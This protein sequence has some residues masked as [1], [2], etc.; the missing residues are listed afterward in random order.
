M[1]PAAVAQPSSRSVA[2]RYLSYYTSGFVDDTFF[3]IIGPTAG[4]ALQCCTRAN[5]SAAWYSL[6]AVLY[7]GQL[8]Q[9]SCLRRLKLP[10]TG[11]W[12]WVP[13]DRGAHYLA[14]CPCSLNRAAAGQQ[15]L[16][17]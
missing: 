14:P 1:L 13:D 9:H 15:I 16:T 5:D 8:T 2:T 10:F 17:L 3:R 11:Q 4:A 6:R 12:A 7:K